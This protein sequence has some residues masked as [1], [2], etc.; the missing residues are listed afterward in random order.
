MKI[1]IQSTMHKLNIFRNAAVAFILLGLFAFTQVTKR[2]VQSSSVSFVIKNFGLDV[3]GSF[4]DLQVNEFVY[5][6]DS[7]SKC[8]IDISIGAKTVKTRNSKRDE[9]LR[10]PD[11]FS[12]TKHPRIRMRSKRFGKSKAGNAIG[13]FNLTMK[14]VTKEVKIPIFVSKTGSTTQFKSSFTIN[15]LDYGVGESSMALSDDVQVSVVIKTN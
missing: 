1:E 8:K 4:K 5:D 11:Y 12:A 13:Y 7:L 14:G 6:S 15:R 2:A 10:K 3:E 9:H